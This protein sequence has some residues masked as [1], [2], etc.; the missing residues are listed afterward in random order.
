MIEF[1]YPLVRTWTIKRLFIPFNMFQATLFIY[2]NFI[3]GHNG[4]IVDRIDFPMQMLLGM[5]AF[6]FLQNEAT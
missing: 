1:N 6:Y 2:L 4:V 3:F 5:F